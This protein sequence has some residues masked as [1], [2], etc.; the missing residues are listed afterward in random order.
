MQFSR[1]LSRSLL[2]A[3]ALGVTGTAYSQTKTVKAI[4]PWDAVGHAFNV[5]PHTVMFQG[6][7]KG[8]IYVETAEGQFNEGF[9]VCPITQFVD[10]NAHTTSAQ[11]YCEIVGDGGDVVYAEFQCDGQVGSCDGVFDLK[12][13]SGRF[14]GITGSSK[15]I[16]R[17][18][19]HAVMGEVASDSVIRVSSGL[20]ILP[21]VTYTL[22]GK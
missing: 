19:I 14:E 6:S 8:V 10:L 20:A 12:G 9:V 11:G 3:A 5:R 7:L 15:L 1:Y 21:D 17:S 2:L 22:P 4:I 16:V 13:G 18:P